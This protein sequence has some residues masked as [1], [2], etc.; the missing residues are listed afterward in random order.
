MEGTRGRLG[1]L[2]L[3]RARV[4]TVLRTCICGNPSWKQWA[5]GTVPPLVILS[6]Y[7]PLLS[8]PPSVDQMN[9]R[10]IVHLPVVF[11][12]LHSFMSI[13]FLPARFQSWF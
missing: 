8:C 11:L 10:I 3:S 12:N 6:K 4:R 5:L 9:Q 7:K 2:I 13:Y 1:R